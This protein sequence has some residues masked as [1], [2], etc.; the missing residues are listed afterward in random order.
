MKRLELH[1]GSV[2]HEEELILLRMS[3][4]EMIEHM[5]EIGDNERCPQ[6]YNQLKRLVSDDN[7][8]GFKVGDKVK[9][10]DDIQVGDGRSRMYVHVEMIKYLENGGIIEVIDDEDSVHSVQSKDDIETGNTGWW[11]D[12]NVLELVE[13]VDE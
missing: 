3:M 1:D 7:Y 11:I 8:G 10:V 9:L 6:R 13:G 4:L 12:E 2:L 5:E